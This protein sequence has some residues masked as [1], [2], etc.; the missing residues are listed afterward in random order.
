MANKLDIIVI[1]GLLWY[2]L[3]YFM[4]NLNHE[5]EQAVKAT[6]PVLVLAGAGAG[7]TRTIIARII[8]L[9][10]KGA[11]PKEI[12]AITFTNKAAKE[13][14][15]RVRHALL[16]HPIASRDR[17]EPWVGTFHAL[18]AEL[19]RKHGELLSIKRHFS[20]Y[21]RG[22]SRQTIKHA[23][24]EM[25]IDPKQFDPARMLSAISREKGNLSTPE[26]LKGN[27]QGD[28][29]PVLIARIW[30]RYDALLAKDQALDFDDILQKAVVLLER[31]PE[32]LAHYQKQW[33]FIHVDEYQDTNRAQ[34]A[35]IEL[36]AREHK[37]LFV[38]GD[39][40]QT[41]YTWRGAYIQNLL[42]F[43]KSY[44][45]TTVVL[46]EDNYRSTKTIIEAA[47][48][49]IKKNTIR[50]DKTLRTQNPQG[51]PIGVYAAYDENDE[52]LFVAEKS[53][54]LINRGVS[55]G[56]IAV[57][58][59]AN[60][61][62]RV[63]EQ[64]F[65]EHNIPYQVL[66]TRFFERKEVK[67]VLA[68]IRL[69]LNPDSSGDLR[70]IINVPAR[71]IGKLTILK[72][73]AG[74]EADLPAGMHKKIADFRNLLERIKVVALSKKPSETIKFVIRESGLETLF[75]SKHEEDVERLENIRELA[76]VATSYDQLSPQEGIEKLLA[77]VSLASEQDELSENREAVRLMTVHAAKGL[78]F[79]SVF[80][81]GLEQDL[82]PHLRMIESQTPEEAEEERR[83]F[84]VAI[85]RARTKVFLTYANIRTTFGNRH[86]NLPSEFLSD[87]EETAWQNETPPSQSPK[88]IF[89]D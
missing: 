47:N 56:S 74:K 27:G 10:T 42:K 60:F 1:E 83:L 50:Y 65:L 86:T 44:P 40:D 4:D 8:H 62:S 66:G 71:G 21:N 45:G 28:R 2:S 23:M 32:I 43:E 87:I 82:F 75:A 24:E 5:Q 54:E 61:Q 14:R 15:E 59:R 46:L 67:D 17:E 48:A 7:K 70:R 49:V 53:R 12:L 31:H 6:G 63:L 38:V 13:M 3:C 19:L 41:I 77:D 55:A 88:T 9:I 72:I 64:A 35:L 39:V 81:T 16:T 34:Y 52:A 29:G 76:T 79:N 22:D 37:N 58:Y 89:F 80:I 25:G 69:A 85:T 68:F 36:L 30:E 20:I 84:Y 78:E 51:E 18:C 26:K 73:L 33:K 11:S 57:L